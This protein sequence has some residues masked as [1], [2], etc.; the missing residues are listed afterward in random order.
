MISA[1]VI[2]G[3]NELLEERGLETKDGEPFGDS[4]AR[5]LDIS[6][7][8]AEVF[9]EALNDG[10]TVDEA[11]HRAGVPEPVAQG[12][13][14]RRIAEAIGSTIGRAARQV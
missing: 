5:A 13:L 4:V 7:A 11:V 2:K 6:P 12:D 9:L 3:V 8:Q 10:A 14:L 1:Q